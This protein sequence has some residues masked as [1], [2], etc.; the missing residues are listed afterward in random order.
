MKNTEVVEGLDFKTTKY[1]LVSS[2]VLILWSLGASII[3]AG[4]VT[5]SII[6]YSLYGFYWYYALSKKNPL[7][8]KL[9]IFGTVAGVMELVTDHY[10]VEWIDSLVY[11][12]KEWMIWSSPAYMPFAWSNVILQLGFIGVLLTQKT[13]LW[14]ASIILGIAGGMYIPLYEHLAKDAGW[15]W[16]HDNTTMIL[17]APVY[18]IICEALIS[19]SLP[20][21]IYYAEH[22]KPTKAVLL[23]LAEGVWILISAILA[24][25]IA[26]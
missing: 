1:I 7:I 19:L 23:G 26:H 18:V 4:P 11:P 22:H 20:L 14:K 5:A 21:V 17:N 16:Y 3:E 13:N 9:V 6:T 8:L 12:S 25:T 10:L 2:A 15:W 24:F